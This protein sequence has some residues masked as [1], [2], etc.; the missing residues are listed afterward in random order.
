MTADPYD[1]HDDETPRPLGRVLDEDRG[2]LPFA[3]IHGEALV[4]CAGWALGDAG[5]QLLDEGTP[6]EEV[7]LAGGALVLHDSLCPMTPA[8]FIADCV[9]R[10]AETGRVVVAVRPVTDTIKEVDSGVVG[11]TVDR[12]EL[13]SVCS[14]LVLPAAV[15]AALP[16]LPSTD[17]VRMLEALEGLP[18][19]DRVELVEAPPQARRV[20]DRDDLVVLEQL[21]RDT[22]PGPGQV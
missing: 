20:A 13:R 18:S 12:D 15:V 2:S 10:A 11:A 9:A 3:L 21:T 4:A 6:W 22:R 8:S 16:E 1:V 5:V 17:L 7:Q 19:G 14:P